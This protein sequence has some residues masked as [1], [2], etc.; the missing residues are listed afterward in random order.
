MFSALGAYIDQD[1]CSPDMQS[2]QPGTTKDYF[3]TVPGMDQFTPND[4]T[5]DQDSAIGKSVK[6]LSPN[7]SPADS[8]IP[9]TSD[10][11][12]NYNARRGSSSMSRRGS[13][14]LDPSESG[15]V[16]RLHFPILDDDVQSRPVTP[17]GR[18]S[19]KKPH[20]VSIGTSK[21]DAEQSLQRYIDARN[22]VAFLCGERL[23][24]SWSRQLPFDIFSKLFVMLNLTDVER[25]PD[26]QKAVNR[27]RMAEEIFQT[28]IEELELD[29]VSNDDS[30]IIEGLILGEKWRSVRLFHEAYI[31]AAGRWDEL[32]HHPGIKMVS[33]VTT[34]RLDRAWMNLHQIRMVNIL[35]RIPNFEFASV[36][37][38]EGRYSDYKG[39]RG[40]YDR[41]R[42]LFMNQMKATFGSW[43]PKAGKH[44]KGEFDLEHGGLNRIVL[45][46]LYED[47]CR[48]YDLTVDREWLGGERINFESPSKN[49]SVDFVERDK[50]HRAVMGKIFAEFD[51]CSA[52]VQPEMPFNQPLIPYRPEGP[53]K[54][55]KLS[56]FSK[57][58]KRIKA[59]EINGVLS[60]SYNMD[61]LEQTSEINIVKAFMQMEREFGTG[62]MIDDLISARRGAWI[63]LY[64]LLQSLVI[65]VIDAHGLRHGDGVEYF[66]CEYV[67]GLAPWEKNAM[68]RQSR[69]TGMW[70]TAPDGSLMN[71]VGSTPE[72]GS[73][74][75]DEIE[76][77]YRRSHCWIVS[78]EWRMLPGVEESDEDSRN[79][80]VMWSGEYIP[81]QMVPQSPRVDSR[82]L[83]PG[84]FPAYGEET[85]PMDGMQRQQLDGYSSNGQDGL[86]DTGYQAQQQHMDP[87][88]QPSPI[89]NYQQR[90]W[91]HD[92]HSPK[93][94]S[95]SGSPLSQQS[96][97]SQSVQSQ[98]YN[99]SDLRSPSQAPL[100]LTPTDHSNTILSPL[101]QLHPFEFDLTPLSEH[102]RFSPDPS[103]SGTPGASRTT[104]PSDH[105]RHSS[106]GAYPPHAFS[107][108]PVV[109]G[110]R[111][112]S[113]PSA[114]RPGYTSFTGRGDGSS[115]PYSSPGNSPVLGPERASTMPRRLP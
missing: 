115:S 68:K 111:K 81:G 102:E 52:P 46:K 95:R 96:P 47:G 62:K 72:L 19:S 26:D 66:L 38:G 41:M 30:A 40:G 85:M 11:G 69:M 63:F 78:E 97:Q 94:S 55:K 42:S 91:S 61:I 58:S 98:G 89:Q 2:A 110:H 56:I 104:T 54:K 59:E 15:V 67:K 99:P 80:S 14:S 86:Y 8:S 9:R 92:G 44:G 70:T 5:E 73:H 76:L 23:V 88:D 57:S 71:A 75:D 31:H 36:W 93:N 90:N 103:G 79:S 50:R 18:K 27:L 83:S 29:D 51:K 3:L 82:S 84:E 105:S 108:A 49:E 60:R 64:C 77:T 6:E 17:G 25:N 35:L 113:A 65:A 74:P 114:H 33:K 22:L 20:H 43:P 1:H 112:S 107:P 53:A 87:S 4:A 101:V 13:S 24:A 28:Y 16:Y 106:G 37:V 34:V 7:S 21:N 45:R 100:P 109:S 32:D 12:M 10:E 39:W 48:I